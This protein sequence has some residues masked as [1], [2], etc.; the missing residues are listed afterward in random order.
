VRPGDPGCRGRTKRSGF[1][2]RAK[3]SVRV[4]AQ[5]SSRIGFI[6]FF[7]DCGRNPQ[8]ERADTKRPSPR[9]RT[10]RPSAL[11]LSGIFAYV[12][13]SFS[14]PQRQRCS[15]A[16]ES[17]GVLMPLTASTWPPDSSETPVDC[18]PGKPTYSLIAAH[19][20]TQIA[21]KRRDKNLTEEWP[22]VRGVSF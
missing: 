10:P 3:L 5:F 21:D 20:H 9:K 11:Q 2:R 17:L 15:V 1:G 18:P 14:R 12:I 16:D 22:S 19:D 7:D 4:P 6:V 8:P 13:C